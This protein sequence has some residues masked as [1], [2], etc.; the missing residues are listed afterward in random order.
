MKKKFL[1]YCCVVL[2]LAC[3]GFFIRCK[4]NRAQEPAPEQQTS[5]EALYKLPEDLLY[6]NKPIPDECMQ[7]LVPCNE[8]E[9]IDLDTFFVGPKQGN[10][11]GEEEYVDHL[12]D[13]DAFEWRYIGTLSNGDHAVYGYYWPASGMAKLSGI[14]IVHRQD[15]TL[16]TVAGIAVGSRHATM[17]LGPTAD[18]HDN[19]LTYEQA[20]TRGLLFYTLLSQHPELSQYTEHKNDEE[21]YWGES[22][23]LG[24]GTYEVIFTPQGAIKTKQLKSFELSERGL[25]NESDQIYY[26]E[27]IQHTPKSSLS[28]GEALDAILEYYSYQSK[29]RTLT[30]DQLV[31]AMKEA[32]SY[33]RDE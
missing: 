6:H 16:K 11:D 24:V 12:S 1:I 19:V 14:D 21:L 13:Q 22:D 7:K 32:C 10:G 28:M 27:W 26:D 3:F 15:N 18:L 8:G 31:E 20:M 33:A 25:W 9:A 23:F 4:K 17:I 5:S 2:S 30:I 29:S